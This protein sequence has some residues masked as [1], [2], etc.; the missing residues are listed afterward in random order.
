MTFAL[1]NKEPAP[2]KEPALHRSFIVSINKA[3]SYTTEMIEIGKKH[4][5]ISR[6]YKLDVSKALQA[7]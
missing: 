3:E 7:D 5:P 6:M 1:Q 2:R 4:S